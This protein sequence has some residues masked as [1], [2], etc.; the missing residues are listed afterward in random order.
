MGR[1]PIA[2]RPEWTIL[3]QTRT[4]IREA[5]SRR[6][7]FAPQDAQRATVIF[8]VGGS[9]F[10]LDSEWFVYRECLG[11]RGS[12]R[13]MTEPSGLSGFEGTLFNVWG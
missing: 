11:F 1:V 6:S 10:I 12:R 9:G 13:N 7:G 8:V 5:L 4:F 2:N 3:D